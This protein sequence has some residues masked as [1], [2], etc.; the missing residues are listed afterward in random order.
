[1]K[2]I[3]TLEALGDAAVTDGAFQAMTWLVGPSR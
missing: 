2:E 1:M 3:A